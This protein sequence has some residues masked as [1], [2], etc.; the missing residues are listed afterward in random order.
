MFLH[1]D[2]K[3]INNIIGIKML[4]IQ[5]IKKIKFDIFIL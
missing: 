5:N 2:I 4:Y 1:F 3:I